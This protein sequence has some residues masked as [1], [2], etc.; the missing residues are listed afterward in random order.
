MYSPSRNFPVEPETPSVQLP[1]DLQQ[2]LNSF[3]KRTSES[4][5]TPAAI[6]QTDPII[7]AYKSQPATNNDEEEAH[8][9]EIFSSPEIVEETPA[10]ATVAATEPA[11]VEA[12]PVDETKVSRDPR[13]KPVAELYPA[14]VHQPPPPGLEEEFPAALPV[15]TTAADQPL[16]AMSV[17]EYTVPMPAAIPFGYPAAAAAV[18]AVPQYPPPNMMAAH[19]PMYMTAAPV[20]PQP[21][22]LPF[23]PIPATQMYVPPTALHHD[24]SMIPLPMDS[25]DQSNLLKR[26]A[27]D[28]I[29]DDDDDLDKGR[30]SDSKTKKNQLYYSSDAKSRRSDSR[31][32]PR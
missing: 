31:S 3:S 16:I 12:A 32:P 14:P 15:T 17:A 1:D 8:I 7:S 4:T 24:P 5:T 21:G 30:K 11:V 22:T 23:G 20:F 2:L 25:G 19:P 6:L 29:D 13:R 26:K 10:A 9:E 27:T 28:D 18:A